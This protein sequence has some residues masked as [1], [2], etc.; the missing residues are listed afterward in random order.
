MTSPS[1][2]FDFGVAWL[3]LAVALALHVADEAANNFL[4][5]YNPRAL[6]I[7]RRLHVPF[8]PVFTYRTWF[9][10]LLAGIALLFLLSPAAFHGARWIRIVALPLSI[11]VGLCNA[12]G[13]LIGSMIYRRPLAGLLSSPALLIGGSWLLWASLHD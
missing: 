10:G 12:A 1:A 3:A 6:A 13:H 2:N 11:L 4:A 7:R 9:A 5:F 8:P